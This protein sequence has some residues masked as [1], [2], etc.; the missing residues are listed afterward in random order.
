LLASPFAALR[1]GWWMASGTL[2]PL[3]KAATALT[4]LVAA[5]SALQPLALCELVAYCLRKGRAGSRFT[6][7]LPPAGGLS[8]GVMARCL[9]DGSGDGGEGGAGGLP[10]AAVPA[11]ASGGRVGPGWCEAAGLD[12]W[13]L[14]TQNLLNSWLCPLSVGLEPMPCLVRCALRCVD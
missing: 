8:P 2:H 11:G 5:R 3:S 14:R 6:K 10:P 4:Q 13:P 12:P 7:P 1:G 9:T